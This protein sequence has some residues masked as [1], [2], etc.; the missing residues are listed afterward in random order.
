MS[1]QRLAHGR[2]VEPSALQRQVGPTQARCT[3]AAH[4]QIDAAA[5]RVEIHQERVAGGLRQRDREQR[6]AGTAAAPDDGDDLT[7]EPV[8]ARRFGGFGELAD[9]FALL[10]G[11]PQH[12]LGTDG[13]GC[14][15]GR[16]R[17]F[18]DRSAR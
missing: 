11:Q 16:R 9:Q 5:P 8:V 13:D 4:Q 3:L 12:M 10:L 15:P 1:R 14:R 6:R 7:A 2:P 17:G 18:G